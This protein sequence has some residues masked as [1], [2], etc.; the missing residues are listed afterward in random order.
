MTC[1]WTSMLCLV[2]T[3]LIK[4]PYRTARA[5]RTQSLFLC[6]CQCCAAKCLRLPSRSVVITWWKSV[7]FNG[8]DW[9]KAKAWS[10]H[11]GGVHRHHWAAERS[12]LFCQTVVHMNMQAL[13]QDRTQWIS[14]AAKP[15]F[16]TLV[17]YELSATMQVMFYTMQGINVWLTVMTNRSALQV[18]FKGHVHK[19]KETHHDCTT[20]PYRAKQNH[21]PPALSTT[22]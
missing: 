7:E 13:E 6:L 2:N 10:L 8:G 5:R 4:G 15:T 11:H 3:A 18:K 17:H 14:S 20:T 19:K 12:F 16:L 22:A 1:P 21:F 9:A